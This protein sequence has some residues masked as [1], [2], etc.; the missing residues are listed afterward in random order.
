MKGIP[1]L[2]LLEKLGQYGYCRLSMTEDIKNVSDLLRGKD[3]RSSERYSTPYRVDYL[4]WLPTGIAL[5][6]TEAGDKQPSTLEVDS[7]WLAQDEGRVSILFDIDGI[8]YSY[9][10]AEWQE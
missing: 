2:K 6:A 8:E 3:I 4:T 9:T 5:T 7:L 10:L 1:T